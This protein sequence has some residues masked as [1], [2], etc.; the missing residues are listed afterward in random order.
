V[1]PRSPG[2]G[3]SAPGGPSHHESLET[4]RL[5]RER[6][7]LVEE[8]LGLRLFRFTLEVPAASSEQPV[9]ALGGAAGHVEA[10]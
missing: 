3:A 5:R 6:V 1:S 4:L 7:G 8:E 9:D 10:A 2:P